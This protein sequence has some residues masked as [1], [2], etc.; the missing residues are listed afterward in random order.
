MPKREKLTAVVITQDE[1]FAVPVLLDELLARR[2]DRIAAVFLADD[3]RAGGLMG[4]IKRWGAVFDP[5]T[6]VRYGVRYVAAKLLGPS[7]QQVARR[8]GVQVDEVAKVNAPKFLDR[9]REMQ[10]DLVISAACPQILREEILSLPPLG[11]INVHSA[12]LPRYRGMLPTFWVLYEH[13]KETAVTV[14]MMNEELDDGPI[15]MQE[16]VPILVRG[17][18]RE[19]QAELMRR[20]KVVGGRLLAQAIDL[21]EMGE[22]Q[23]RPNRRDEATYYSLPTREQ[24]RRFRAEGGRWL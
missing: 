6:F 9:L 19:T 15:I 10:V 3:P 12:P 24:A 5:W 14:H 2:A 1:P 13:E 4:A 18:R 20:C 11:C 8:H 16:P 22:V 17:G 23:T 21:F 7:P